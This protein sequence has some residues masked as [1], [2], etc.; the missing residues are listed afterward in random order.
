MILNNI[1]EC[2]NNN[3]RSFVKNLSMGNFM[4]LLLKTSPL[5]LEMN[6]RGNRFALTNC[7]IFDG[8]HPELKSNMT[9]LIEDER[10]FDVEYC[11]HIRIPGKWEKPGL[12]RK[13]PGAKSN[14]IMAP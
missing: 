14:K 8:S 10:I 2:M 12:P 3:M 5:S 11:E 13:G 7:N 9:V 1:F 6:K 4:D